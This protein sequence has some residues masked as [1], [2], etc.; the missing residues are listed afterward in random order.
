MNSKGNK[1]YCSF[2]LSLSFSHALLMADVLYISIWHA[3]N[4]C[5]IG[6][7]SSVAPKTCC[8]FGLEIFWNWQKINFS[9][10]TGFLFW[11]RWFLGWS[12]AENWIRLHTGRVGGQQ[13]GAGSCGSTHDLTERQSRLNYSEEWV[14]SLSL[15]PRYCMWYNVA[16]ADY[17]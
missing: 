17:Y 11:L 8:D 2:S 16:A 14:F 6:T 15:T 12:A 4:M 10:Q 13:P 7:S 1:I 5:C 9:S 3:A